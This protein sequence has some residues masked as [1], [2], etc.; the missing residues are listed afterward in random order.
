MFQRK[1]RAQPTHMTHIM[2][3]WGG[4][5]LWRAAWDSY[6]WILTFVARVTSN[7]RFTTAKP[8]LLI[9][10]KMQVTHYPR[11]TKNK[12]KGA[13]TSSN[14]QTSV[15][16]WAQTNMGA[17]TSLKGYIYI[18]I[19]ICGVSLECLPQT[20]S[21]GTCFPS[22]SLP[23]L[24][25]LLPWGDLGLYLYFYLFYRACMFNFHR[26]CGEICMMCLY[27]QLSKDVH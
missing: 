2:H 22:L 10:S 25:R 18:Y 11:V 12:N 14:K 24:V 26:I 9:A 27:V 13:F 4:V 23:V 20:S 6:V 8:V 3:T 5:Q 1:V 16:L 7:D 15:L 17:L 21:S 19:Y